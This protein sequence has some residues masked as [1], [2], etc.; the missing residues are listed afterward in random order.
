MRYHFP[1]SVDFLRLCELV[2][3]VLVNDSPLAFPISEPSGSLIQYPS[4]FLISYPS[5]SLIDY[6]P[7][8]RNADQ[9]RIQKVPK[10]HVADVKPDGDRK[11]ERDKN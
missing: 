3:S 7:G 5:G 8:D 2:S 10:W 9:N 4:G 1:P 11:C 6:P